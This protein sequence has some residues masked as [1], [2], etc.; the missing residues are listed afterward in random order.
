[1]LL[2]I[3]TGLFAQDINHLLDSVMSSDLFSKGIEFNVVVHVDVPGIHMPDK[4]VL[5]TID[6]E[7]KSKIKGEG[8]LL[9]PQKGIFGQFEEFRSTPNQVI[10]LGTLADTVS[11]KI[12]SLDSKS[13]WITADVFIN[14]RLKQLIRM[15][16]TTRKY[17]TFVVK[18]NYSDYWYPDSTQVEFKALPVELPLKFMGRN[19]QSD[20]KLENGQDIT[21]RIVLRYS[22][23]GQFE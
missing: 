23:E 4:T 15:E 14:K 8:L 11:Y 1:M 7:G 10:W 5:V 20:Y 12:V 13:D 22:M 17:G 2:F 18:H 16:I 19:S 9:L 3:Q 21:G 6:S